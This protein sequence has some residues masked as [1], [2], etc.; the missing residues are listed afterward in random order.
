M[1]FT[2]DPWPPMLICGLVGLLGVG[3]WTSSRRVAHLAIAVGALVLGGIVYVVEGAIIT[4]A[5]AVEQS[6]I[7]LCWEF[8]RKDAR[9]LEHFSQTAPELSTM[10][11]A[12][13]NM[14]EVDDDLRLT[15]FQT[16]ESNNGSRM[17]CHF[18]ANASMSVQGFGRVGHQP[19]RLELTL[20]KEGDSW[21]I[22][23]V[24]R[25]HPLK[26]EEMD[27]MARSAG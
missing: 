8:Q 26:D 27:V 10:C 2:E 13:M 18:R 4:P 5:E 7:D 22:I 19:L 20:A 16:R 14:V 9:A 1:W 3:W 25:L 15:D 23:A 24:R 12:A 11:Q 21:K 17:T 6:V